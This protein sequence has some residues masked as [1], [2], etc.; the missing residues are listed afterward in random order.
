MRLIAMKVGLCAGL[1]AASPAKAQDWE[2]QVHLYGWLSG[3]SGSLGLLPGYPAQPVDMSFSDIFDT[4]DYAGFAI[5]TA[6][7]GPWLLYFDGEAV[8]TTDKTSVNASGID[9]FTTTS[10]SEFLTLGGGHVIAEGERYR[11]DAWAGVRL[12]WMDYEFDIATS[13]GRVVSASRSASWADPMIGLDGSYRL[14]EKWAA[15]GGVDFGGFGVGARTEWD[16]YGALQYRLSER[17]DLDFGYRYLSVDY[18]DDGF[19]YDMDQS[20]PLLGVNLRF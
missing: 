19:V 7:N 17:V 11:V 2:F 10:Y 13:G 5:A 15:V 8:K 18:R 9:S 14:G 3:L 1:L 16:V 12:W 20:G 4:L 6:R